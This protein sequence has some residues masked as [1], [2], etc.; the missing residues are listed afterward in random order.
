MEDK[1]LENTIKKIL[2]TSFRDKRIG[3]TPTDNLQLTPR[4]YV[5]MN[6]PIASRPASVLAVKGQQYY[7]T[8][9][10]IPLFYDGSKWRNGVGSIIASN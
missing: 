10:N 4:S 1:K 3:T 5:N 6:G 8:D 7:A 2:T 9:I